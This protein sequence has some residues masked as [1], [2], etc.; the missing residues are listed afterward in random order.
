M[1]GTAC[2]CRGCQGKGQECRPSPGQGSDSVT[3]RRRMTCCRLTTSQAW[4]SLHSEPGCSLSLSIIV[5][6]E[7]MDDIHESL[8]A[9]STS[10]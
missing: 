8:V 4:R 10:A 5:S 2:E 1:T 7:M 9:L 6:V 3:S